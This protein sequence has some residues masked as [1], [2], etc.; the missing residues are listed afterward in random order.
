MGSSPGVDGVARVVHV[1][2]VLDTLLAPREASPGVGLP[3]GGVSP[4]KDLSNGMFRFDPGRVV[5]VTME[6]GRGSDPE[7]KCSVVFLFPIVPD[8]SQSKT[9]GGRKV[10][11]VLS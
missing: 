10:C 2:C 11:S 7:S 6:S 8:S 1:V 5:V 9:C 3:G 4:K